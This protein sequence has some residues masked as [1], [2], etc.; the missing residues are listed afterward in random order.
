MIVVGGG[1]SGL[2]L[3][4][5]LAKTGNARRVLIIDDEQDSIT[6]RNWGF[7]AAS[8]GWGSPAVTSAWTA[9]SIRAA[10]TRVSTSI[11][12]LRY[13][14]VNGSAMRDTARALLDASHIQTLRAHVSDVRDGL[15]FATVV[16]EGKEI[17]ARWVFD[18]RPPDAP[19]ARTWMTFLGRR[20][21]TC[22]PAFDP[23]EMTFM[24]FRA[25]QRC[26]AVFAHVLPRTDREAFV[27]VVAIAPTA[28]A[29]DLDRHLIEYL[30]EV[31]G[32]TSWAVLDSESGRLPLDAP[33]IRPGRHVVPIGRRAGMLKASTG[34]AF[35]RVQR[36]SECIY[37]SLTTHG[38]PFAVP[39]ARL[40]Y[41]WMDAVLLEVAREDP[42]AIG[43]A[44][45]SL[46]RDNDV[47]TVLRFLDEDASPLDLLRVV[48]SLPASPFARAALR[49]GRIRAVHAGGNGRPCR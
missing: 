25:P 15:G 16:T 14:S 7:W 2:S 6:R 20:V 28:T 24:D 17:R 18:S 13:W 38:H 27:E 19:R 11:L 9:M 46:F 29:T 12:P 33:R 36:H 21:A 48:T 34:Y 45:A 39:R 4:V 1:L 3:A 30:R 44:L 49:V 40:H 10:G 23:Q 43:P 42:A 8:P 31:C 37:R 41:A 35:A 47:S 26:G 5:R 22:G 32:G